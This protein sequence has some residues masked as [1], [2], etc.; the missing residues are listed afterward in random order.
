MGDREALGAAVFRQR[1]PVSTDVAA[2]SRFTGF[3]KSN[4]TPW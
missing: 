4:A 2:C 3:L 1:E